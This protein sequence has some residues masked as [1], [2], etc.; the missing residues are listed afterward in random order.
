MDK[1]ICEICGGDTLIKQD[2]YF[3]CKECGACYS[4][5]QL[6]TTE[7]TPQKETV[8]K[9]DTLKTKI[10]IPSLKKIIKHSFLLLPLALLI[11]FSVWLIHDILIEEGVFPD[12]E[13]VKKFAEFAL[14]DTLDT[15]KNVSLETIHFDRVDAQIFYDRDE[16]PIGFFDSIEEPITFT[17]VNGK[18]YESQLAYYRSKHNNYDPTKSKKWAYILTGTYDAV[19]KDYGEI[20]G[21]FRYTYVYDS[22]YHEWSYIDLEYKTSLDVLRRDIKNQLNTY[23]LLTY[24]IK[25]N[26]QIKFTSIDEDYDHNDYTVYGKVVVTDK[27]G[28]EYSGKFK[29]VYNYN[30]YNLLFEKESIEVDELSKNIL[31]NNLK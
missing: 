18:E 13:Q 17:D 29:A 4:I 9:T 25:P 10:K 26:P 7:T 20:P 6:K 11:I 28:E 1:L 8:A 16:D 12:K 30:Q 14:K 21:E 31:S 5:E 24:D 27:Y 23:L 15:D 2:D 19:H 3:R 22:K